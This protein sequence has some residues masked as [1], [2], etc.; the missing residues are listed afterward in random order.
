M[1]QDGGSGLKGENNSTL[2]QNHLDLGLDLEAV[3]LGF[4]CVQFRGDFVLP[5]YVMKLTLAE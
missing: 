3:A 5:G 4:Q 1:L 2:F